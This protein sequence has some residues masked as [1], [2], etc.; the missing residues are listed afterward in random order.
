MLRTEKG[1]RAQWWI[2]DAAGA[3][4]GN[5][6]NGAAF[7]A[8]RAGSLPAMAV[9]LAILHCEINCHIWKMGLRHFLRRMCNENLFI[10][11]GTH[12]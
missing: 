2:R 1:L 9:Q 6:A 7:R 4:A 12:E 5:A 10:P 3:I 8:C 11:E